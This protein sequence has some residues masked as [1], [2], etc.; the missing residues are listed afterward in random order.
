M[1]S[2][3]RIRV[4]AAVFVATVVATSIHEF[5]TTLHPNI[6]PHSD[7]TRLAVILTWGGLTAFGL[8]GY[9]LYR[10]GRTRPGLFCL[11]VFPILGLIPIGHYLRPG[12]STIAAWRQVVIA[13]C[14]LSAATLLAFVLAAFWQDHTERM[15]EARGMTV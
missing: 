3:R 15:R 2:G 8:I 5:D 9:A 14:I 10:S 12:L 11:T 13:S 1:R 6:Y 4:P 7:A